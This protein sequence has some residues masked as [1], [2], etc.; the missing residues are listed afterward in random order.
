MPASGRGYRQQPGRRDSE[1][2]VPAARLLLR[3]ASAGHL[4]R[5]GEDL[6]CARPCR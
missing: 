1:D 2:P 6:P 3:P 4:D 5:Q